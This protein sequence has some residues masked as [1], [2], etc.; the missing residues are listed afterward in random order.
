MNEL[1]EG[2]TTNLTAEENIRAKEVTEHDNGNDSVLRL[3][4][5]LLVRQWTKE[6]TFMQA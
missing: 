1:S 4:L 6:V 3:Q 2:N 5:S